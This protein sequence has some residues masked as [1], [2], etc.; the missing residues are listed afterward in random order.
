MKTVIPL[1]A[2]LVFGCHP[3]YSQDPGMDAANQAAQIA[4]QISLQAQQEQI[5][6]QM[7]TTNLI[8]LQN[9]M[10]MFDF[11]ESTGPVIGSA[12]KP[13]FS[14]KSGKVD[15]GTIVRLQSPTHYAT[16]YYTTDG[17]SPTAASRRYAGPITVDADTHIQALAVGPNLLH[18]PVVRADYWTTAPSKSPASAPAPA[19]AIVTDGVLHAGTPLHLTTTAEIS[20]KTAQVGDKVSLALDQD[21]NVG[22][23]VVLAKGTPVDAILTSPTRPEDEASQAT[24]SSKFNPSSCRARPSLSVAPKLWKANLEKMAEMPSSNPPCPSSPR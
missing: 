21:V 8:N 16:I 19:P 7:N 17:W 12:I 3:S 6:Q 20:S 1:L 15:P 23:T 9:T 5:I 10:N 2:M 22:N 14:V 11:P 24:S 18:S 4:S 13:N